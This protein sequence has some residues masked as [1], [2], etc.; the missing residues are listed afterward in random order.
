VNPDINVSMNFWGFYPGIFNIFKAGFEEFIRKEKDNL[1]S[2]Y[3]IALPLT[4][5][6]EKGRGKIKII[7]TDARW[8][9]VTY[10]EDK[11][12]AVDTISRLVKEGKYPDNLWK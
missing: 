12:S 3:Y 1:K 9:G 11:A 8:F 6:I 7:E 4:D 2:E 5:M 10:R